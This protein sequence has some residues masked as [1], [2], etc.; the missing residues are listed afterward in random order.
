MQ[1][2]GGRAKGSRRVCLVKLCVRLNLYKSTSRKD[3]RV[4]DCWVQSVGED[5]LRIIPIIAVVTDLVS[6][7]KMEQDAIER[8]GCELNQVRAY[9]DQEEWQKEV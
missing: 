7:R 5:T 8:Y 4:V 2:V 6:L 3:N 9:T 1:R